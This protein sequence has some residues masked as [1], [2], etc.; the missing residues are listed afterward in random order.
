MTYPETAIIR[1]D[2]EGTNSLLAKAKVEIVALVGIGLTNAGD[3]APVCIQSTHEPG[4]VS[5]HR[6][7]ETRTMGGSGTTDRVGVFLQGPQFRHKDEW[8]LI[9]VSAKSERED[10]V[11]LTSTQR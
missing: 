3:S 5:R 9:E 2:T 10:D 7:L 8:D 6:P 11:K 4:H 1:D